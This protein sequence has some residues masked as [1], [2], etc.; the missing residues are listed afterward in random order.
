MEKY[1]PTL[2]PERAS[3][4]AVRVLVN[5]LDKRTDVTCAS[6]KFFLEIG[7]P[8]QI[9]DTAYISELTPPK[10]KDVRLIANATTHIKLAPILADFVPK[11]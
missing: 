9:S 8:T 5:E 4:V 3:S 11:R 2:L 1:I 10:M 6:Y 7:S